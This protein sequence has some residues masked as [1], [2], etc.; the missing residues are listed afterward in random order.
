M[1]A[2]ALDAYRPA[3][4]TRQMAMGLGSVSLATSTMMLIQASCLAS[5]TGAT[6]VLA[7]LGVGYAA[8]GAKL[9]LT[10]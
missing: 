1:T 4:L 10:R 5:I 9:L 8:L 3:G 7:V 2:I 6:A